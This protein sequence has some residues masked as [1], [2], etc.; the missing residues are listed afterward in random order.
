M[1]KSLG[2]RIG[3]G[4]VEMEAVNVTKLFQ[5]FIE[6]VVVMINSGIIYSL[7]HLAFL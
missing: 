3:L 1:A 2:L 5:L 6:K 4:D 7:H